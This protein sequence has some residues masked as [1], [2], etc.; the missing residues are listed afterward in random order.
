MIDDK[1]SI[2]LCRKRA[3][4]HSQ[5]REEI[6]EPCQPIPASGPWCFPPWATGK[7]CSGAG[8]PRREAVYRVDRAVRASCW[9]SWPPWRPGSRQGRLVATRAFDG[10]LIGMNRSSARGVFGI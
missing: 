4:R 5:L 3:A 1:R 9:D 2:K 7:R 10:I 8:A 6:L